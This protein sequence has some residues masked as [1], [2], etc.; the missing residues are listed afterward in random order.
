MITERKILI[1]DDDDDLRQSLKEQLAMNQEFGV[2]AAETAAKG[3]D[4]VKNEHLDLV[5]LDVGLPDMDGREMCKHLRKHGFKKPIIMLTGN[6]SDAD[7]IL[8]FDSGANDYI[9][10][11]FKF[12]VL[13]ARIRA[14]LRQYEQS[15]D[16]VFAIG[17]YSFKPAAKILLNQK[18]S[19]IRLTEKETLTLKHLYRAG[20]KAVTSEVLLQ[21]VWGYNSGV[22]T[23]TV[24]THIYRLRQKIEKDPSH[25]EL[26]VTEGGGY[27]LLP[28]VGASLRR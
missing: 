10:K 17:P 11:P 1:V 12:A 28:K 20:E 4:V 7:Q 21:E 9:I 3:I 8:G 5:V 14:H 19:K 23:H 13:L 2:L 24:E 27:K 26:L 25:A 6:A 16:A 22:T 18:G 15:E